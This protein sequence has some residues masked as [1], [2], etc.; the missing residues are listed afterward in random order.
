MQKLGPFAFFIYPFSIISFFTR[1]ILR[2][3]KVFSGLITKDE[4]K[5]KREK[6][7]HKTKKDISTNNQQYNFVT[8]R[9]LEAWLLFF[10]SLLF[11]SLQY[12]RDYF[13][14]NN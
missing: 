9:A 4:E 12:L 3:T 10:F 2:E 6:Q 13:Q 14:S 7:K 11:L 1:K 5:V 8:I